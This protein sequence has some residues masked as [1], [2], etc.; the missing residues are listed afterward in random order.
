MKGK[1]NSFPFSQQLLQQFEE[2]KHLEHER[3]R[4]R[5]I[6]QLQAP[7]HSTLFPL[8][9]FY[10]LIPFNFT[11]LAETALWNPASF[12]VPQIPTF[13]TVGE[14]RKQIVDQGFQ[15]SDKLKKAK[16]GKRKSRTRI[17]TVPECAK[18]SQGGTTFC[19]RHG[20]GKRCSSVGCVKGARG[21]TGFCIAHGGGK[22][23]KE[24]TCQN[25]AVG[26][27][28]FCVS[29]GGGRRCTYENCLKSAQG[30]TKFCVLHGKNRKCANDQC[31]RL[32]L[33]RKNF[34]EVHHQQL[35]LKKRIYRK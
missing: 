8:P 23:C 35:N 27:T 13:Q 16:I 9:P 2:S 29:H 24:A 12:F 18:Y 20:G 21:N 15:E 4:M 10:P 28:Q 6:Q 33:S 14:K 32:A 31:R 3:F 5:T 17:C 26:T 1:L 11:L 34:C 30:A 22:R 25:S 7:L 19:V